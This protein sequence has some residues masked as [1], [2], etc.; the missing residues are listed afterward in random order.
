MQ[1]L[2]WTFIFLVIFSLISS[3]FF[4][5]TKHM[6]ILTHA[7]EEMF[8]VEEALQ[9]SL[10][11]RE[12]KRLLKNKPKKKPMQKHVSLTI[13][14]EKKQ[15]KYPR[16]H[17]FR[18][19]SAKMNLAPALQGNQLALEAQKKLFSYF[20]KHQMPF[21]VEEDF[22]PYIQKLMK[23]HS[24][25]LLQAQTV[26]QLP[27]KETKYQPFFF[28]L[29]KGCNDYNF[30]SPLGFPGLKD[31][32]VIMPSQDRCFSFHHL[33]KP[34]LCAIFSEEFANSLI[35]EEKDRFENER[36]EINEESFSN[37][38]KEHGFSLQWLD[39]IDFSSHH[40]EKQPLVVSNDSNSNFYIL[41]R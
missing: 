41:E 32:F 33:P 21:A 31:I 17:N 5:A 23:T 24:K 36:E 2:P 12:Y 20:Y 3:Q 7:S 26:S 38:L 37:L 22:L 27:I 18:Q 15:Y 10:I 25:T 40:D 19:E 14:K 4:H 8:Q 11:K 28:T 16:S 1:T 6:D 29:Y 34:F 35:E 30:T 9:Q 39:L 13:E